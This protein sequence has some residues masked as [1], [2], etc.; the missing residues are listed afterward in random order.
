MLKKLFCDDILRS[1]LCISFA[2]NNHFTLL[3]WN[4]S[5]RRNLHWTKPNFVLAS[6]ILDSYV[7][8]YSCPWNLLQ[9]CCI[10]L[11]QL[12]CSAVTFCWTLLKFI[13]IIV[14][15]AWR[16]SPNYVLYHTMF[17]L[18]WKPV[19]W[20]LQQMAYPFISLR[21]KFSAKIYN[22]F[23]PFL[24][25]F[26]AAADKI[27]FLTRNLCVIHVLLVWS[28]RVHFVIH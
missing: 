10:I 3:Q 11:T 28:N 17:D 20:V 25:S 9:Y 15:K 18:L 4:C 6:R 22:N 2:I 13:I 5:C 21:V 8:S 24:F 27:N 7:G 19:C 26:S 14:K 1:I 23:N 16:T 12:D